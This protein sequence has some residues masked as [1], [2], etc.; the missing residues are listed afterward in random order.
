MSKQ[1]MVY[2]PRNWKVSYVDL[3]GNEHKI[4]NFV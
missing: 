2:V 1:K 4:Q 3:N